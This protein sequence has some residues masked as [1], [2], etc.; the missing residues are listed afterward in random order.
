MEQWM[1]IGV[2]TVV[3]GTLFVCYEIGALLIEIGV[4]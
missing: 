2:L 3:A 4:V 1:A